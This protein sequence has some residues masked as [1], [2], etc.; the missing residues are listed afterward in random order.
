[1]SRIRLQGMVFMALVT[2]ASEDG[3][4]VVLVFLVPAVPL[5]VQELEVLEMAM[6]SMQP[7]V[8]QTMGPSP[9]RTKLDSQCHSRRWSKQG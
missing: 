1:M 2:P 9:A 8:A 6:I 3:V 7:A 4:P 5:V